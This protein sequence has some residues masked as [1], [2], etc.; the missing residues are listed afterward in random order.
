MSAVGKVQEIWRYPVKSMRGEQ[1]DSVFVAF[2]GLI[3]DRVYGLIN[4]EAD[5]A[6]PWHTAREQEL[7]LLY[8]PHFAGAVGTTR[9]ANLGAAQAAAPSINPVYPDD[10]AFAVRVD[11]PHGDTYELEDPAFLEHLRSQTGKG[12]RLHYTQKGQMDC[13]PVSLLSA[14]TVSTLSGELDMELDRRRFRANVFVDWHDEDGYYEDSLVG[15]TVRIGESLELHI[16]ERDP[17]CKM[18]TLDPDTAETSPRV[19]KHVSRKHEGYTGVYAAVL[20]EGV[21][22]ERDEIELV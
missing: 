11:T 17:R 13:R 8:T 10:S 20:K 15:R 12:L 21:I 2:S 1:L 6:F 14:Q 22:A 5:P 9:P 7:L 4:D 16:L 3:G 19:L 18:I